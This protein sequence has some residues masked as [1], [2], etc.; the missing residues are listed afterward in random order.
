MLGNSSLL[1]AGFNLGW[2]NKR[3]DPTALKFPDQFD[4]SLGFFDSKQPTIV[5]L[6]NTNI[7]YFDMQVGMNYAFFPT[8]DIYVNGGYS[9]HHV[10][11]PR[12]SFFND[13]SSTGADIIPM[14]QI[15]FA[16]AIVKVNPSVILNPNVYYTTQAKA[17]E[18]VIGLNM[19][20]NLSES[21][22]KQLLAG[23]YYRANDAVIPMLGFELNNIRFTFSYDATISSLKD[24]NNYRGALEFS[25]VKKGFYRDNADRQSLCPKF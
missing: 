24:F 19:N 8:E 16:N 1:S 11:K 12:E 18:L 17:S 13:K 2:A 25:L 10:N 9:I 20:Y 22:E 5:S 21:G 7:S 23:V 3:I 14:R 15:A 4:E 6:S